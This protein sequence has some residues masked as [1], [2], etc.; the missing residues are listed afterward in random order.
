[1]TYKMNRAFYTLIGGTH[2]EKLAYVNA[3]LN[4][5]GVI[6][7]RSDGNDI[8]SLKKLLRQ[9][10]YDH[11]SLTESFDKETIKII[12]DIQE[13]YALHVDGQVGPFTKIALYNES[14]EFIKPSL[15]KFEAART[16]NGS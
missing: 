9:L 12:K 11:V 3:L 10:G 7:E 15:V 4:L 2:K 5:K 6:T 13:E 14:R 8:K 16:E 1:M